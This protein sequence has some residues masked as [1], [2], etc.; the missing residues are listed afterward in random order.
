VSGLPS[1]RA[2]LPVARRPVARQVWGTQRR[3]QHLSGAEAGNSRSARSGWAWRANR[4]P[5]AWQTV[6]HAHTIPAVWHS[7]KGI[8]SERLDKQ[9]WER[10]VASPNLIHCP[11]SYRAVYFRRVT[12]AH[13]CIRRSSRLT[14]AMSGPASLAPDTEGHKSMTLAVSP[15]PPSLSHSIDPRRQ[16]EVAPPTHAQ[17]YVAVQLFPCLAA[18]RGLAFPP[19]TSITSRP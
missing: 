19:D 5:R 9:S 16:I 8:T 7:V 4:R 6:L 17:S 18:L 10:W 3:H 12:V 13:S 1:R 14:T 11:D 2:G 15:S